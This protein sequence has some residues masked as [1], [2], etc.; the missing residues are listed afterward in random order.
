MYKRNEGADISLQHRS[1]ENLCLFSFILLLKSIVAWSVVFHDG[2]NWTIVQTELP[3]L[4]WCS[5]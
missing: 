4:S 3:F 5:A 2:T 1:Y